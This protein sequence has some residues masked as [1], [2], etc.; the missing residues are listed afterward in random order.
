MRADEA[1]AAFE[2]LGADRGEGVEQTGLEQLATRGVLCGDVLAEATRL[3]DSAA[4]PCPAETASYAAATNGPSACDEAQ[5][6]GEQVGTDG[7]E[8]AVPDVERPDVAPARLDRRAGGL[9]QGVALPQHAVVVGTHAR[10]TAGRGRR[11]GRRGTGAGR[12]GRP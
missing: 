11:A 1:H 8:V 7:R 10:R 9:E 2:L 5:P 3:Y 4:S 6:A 12:P